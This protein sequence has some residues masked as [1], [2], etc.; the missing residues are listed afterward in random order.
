MAPGWRGARYRYREAYSGLNVPLRVDDYLEIE[1]MA[2]AYLW[3]DLVICRAGALTISE[4]CVVGLARSWCRCRVRDDHQARNAAWLADH[5]AALVLPQE[6]L[7]S[8]LA[9]ELR[10][11]ARDRASLWRL[12][13]A[14][15]A[16]ARPHA[17]QKVVDYCLRE[18]RA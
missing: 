3:A 15:R 7:A 5:G 4:L 9:P 11:L 14:G 2:G 6:Q 12:A 17:A 13:V 18:V 8:R 1:A 16:L 10:R